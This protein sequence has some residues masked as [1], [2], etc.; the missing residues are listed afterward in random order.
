M[1]TNINWNGIGSVQRTFPS[2]PSF[3]IG[4]DD[5]RDIGQSIADIVGYY[6]R[7]KTIDGD[8]ELDKLKSS[9]NDL[10]ARQAEMRMRGAETGSVDVD[11]LRLENE[12]GNREKALKTRLDAVSGDPEYQTARLHYLK[13][14]DRGALDS[15]WRNQE[16]KKL[17][18][19]QEEANRLENEK[20]AAE[21]EKERKSAEEAELRELRE[22]VELLFPK[23]KTAKAKSARGD[24]DSKGEFEDQDT[25]MDVA[26]R[27]MKEKDPSFVDPRE[28][29]KSEG[30]SGIG[31][32]ELTAIKTEIA[33]LAR[34]GGKAKNAQVEDLKKRLEPFKNIPAFADEYQK[35]VGILDGIRTAEK[36][37]AGAETARKNAG[38]FNA[39]SERERIKYG[40]ST[41]I[42]G[43]KYDGELHKMVEEK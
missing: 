34:L 38:N 12:I 23:W 8:P 24:L 40:P 7:E 29:Y 41:K 5:I 16:A 27:R 9:L 39:R 22:N 33:D 13:S 43:W 42:P 1:A 20:V 36:R 2:T 6:E 21:A 28:W 14:G 15:Y 11:I 35:Q 26:V 18:A 10:Y 25:A 31:E 19:A 4:G 30:D 17:R 32:T 37:A 3:S